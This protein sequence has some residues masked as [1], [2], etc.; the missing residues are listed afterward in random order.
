MTGPVIWAYWFY[1]YRLVSQSLG[2]AVKKTW[3]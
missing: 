1:R 3:F 2:A